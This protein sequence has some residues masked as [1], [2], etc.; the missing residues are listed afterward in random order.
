MRFLWLLPA[1]VLINLSLVGP[2]AMLGWTHSIALATVVGVLA[3]GALLGMFLR[4]APTRN[5][6]LVGVG[7]VVVIA[8]LTHWIGTET[9]QLVVHVRQGKALDGVTMADALA[10]GEEGTWIRITDARVRSEDAHQFTF[11][12]GDSRKPASQ[13]RSTVA[14]AP[15][16]LAAE[17]TNEMVP[18]RARVRGP[19]MLWAC[20]TSLGEV[21][22]W[23]SERQAV[24]GRLER[25][26]EKV[27]ASLE[28][29]LNPRDA[30]VPGAGAIPAAPG[31][32]P[33]VAPRPA[34]LSIAPKAW[35]VELD[36][37][38]DAKA[39]GD[40][41]A[42]AAFAF[43]LMLPLFGLVVLAVAASKTLRE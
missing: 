35:C 42:S 14:V 7:I 31:A 22:S 30:I 39:A 17:V 16:T 41:A 19:Q 4:I 10:R 23:D 1:W 25:M 38:L 11:V 29:E 13:T 26:D 34:L 5:S 6:A 28:E 27:V 24:R 40:Q 36:H 18:L 3:L 8:G 33:S 12:R 9:F 37:A 15:V 2:Q 43:L 20:S 21:R 32:S